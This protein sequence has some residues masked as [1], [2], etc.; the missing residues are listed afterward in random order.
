MWYMSCVMCQATYLLGAVLLSLRGWRKKN[1]L[2]RHKK[3]IT[4]I[5]LGLLS[6][7]MTQTDSWP[8]HSSCNTLVPIL[9][10]YP[11]E[12][13]HSYIL[14]CPDVPFTCHRSEY[15][16]TRRMVNQPLLNDSAFVMFPKHSHGYKIESFPEH[17]YI[18][19]RIA[20][21]N[22]EIWIKLDTSPPALW[23]LIWI[24]L[25]KIT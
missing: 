17:S 18:K 5:R 23:K 3:L 8:C 16:Q 10:N 15:K 21:E 1:I 2:Q 7:D 13:E 20:A 22:L 6:K 11:V 19:S 12:S 25:L 14:M 4:F 24:Y 9:L